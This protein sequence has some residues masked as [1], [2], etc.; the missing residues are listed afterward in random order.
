LSF[1]EYACHAPKILPGIHVAEF[2]FLGFSE[3]LDGVLFCQAG[4]LFYMV[5]V[6]SE[7]RGVNTVDSD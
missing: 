6:I 5:T 4:E 7:L 2:D 3:S 1:K